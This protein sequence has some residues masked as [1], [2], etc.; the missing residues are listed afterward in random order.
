M[1]KGNVSG[2][3]QVETPVGR[4]HIELNSTHSLGVGVYQE[5]LFFTVHA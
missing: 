1:L 3:T 4:I 5:L 2:V